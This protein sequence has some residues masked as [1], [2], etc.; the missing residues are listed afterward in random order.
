MF[1][2]YS[3]YNQGAVMRLIRWLRFS[4]VLVVLGAALAADPPGP[5]ATPDEVL[6][7]FVEEFVPLTPGEGKFPASFVM[8]STGDAPDAEKPAVTVTL[9]KPFAVA[10]YEV[11]QELYQTITGRN[12][13]KWKG[14]RNSVEMVSWEEANE[15]CRKATA[16]LRRRRLLRAEEEI[17]LP[18]E[19]EWE[20][21]CRA[22][23]KTTYSFGDKSADLRAYAW[24][25]GNAKGEDPPVGRKKPNAWGLYD[26]HGYVWE[27]CAD[28]WSPT[29]KDAAT[30]GRPRVNKDERECVLRGG[31]WADDA[32]HCRSAFRSHKPLDFRSDAVGF[33]CV[34][35]AVPKTTPKEESR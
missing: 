20:Y 29:H 10:R 30:D 18:S 3:A 26:M 19:A 21:A 28:S 32:D 31:S 6:K 15:F 25:N 16:E 1:P 23:S 17:R 4:C 13:S 7:R 24:F 8:G 27:W 34:R 11:T 12:P 2:S 35:A 22:G 14:R 33:R 5:P 9:R